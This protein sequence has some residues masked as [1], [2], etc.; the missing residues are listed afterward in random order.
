[1][2]FSFKSLFEQVRDYLLGK[3]PTQRRRNPLAAGM[4]G[5]GAGAITEDEATG[6]VYDGDIFFVASSN[7]VTA[8]YFLD[9][10]KMTVEYLRRGKPNA[11]YIYGNVTEQDAISF[12]QAGSKGKFIW[13]FFRVRGTVYGHRK[14]YQKIR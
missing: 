9:E 12:V 4:R 14:P 10:K 6:F 7:V 1:M 13:D 2:A 3:Q 5:T 8:Q 11:V